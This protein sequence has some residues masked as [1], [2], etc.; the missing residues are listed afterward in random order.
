[1]HIHIMCR[2]KIIQLE[3]QFRKG[4]YYKFIG[5]SPPNERLTREKTKAWRQKTKQKILLEIIDISKEYVKFQNFQAFHLDTLRQTSHSHLVFLCNHS[6]NI[7]KRTAMYP[8]QH[9]SLYLYFQKCQDSPSF[10]EEG[11]SLE[12][13]PSPKMKSCR[14]T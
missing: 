2:I 5:K 4:S 7:D 13:V 1:M 8:V 14:A 11:V 9:H 10:P 12:S 6:K 3:F